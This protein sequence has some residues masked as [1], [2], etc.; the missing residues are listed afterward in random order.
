MKLRK[1]AKD[2]GSQVDHCPAVYVAEDDPTVMGRAGEAARPGHDAELHHPLP[3][4]T[5]VRIPA[6]TMVRAVERY[7]AE[8]V[9]T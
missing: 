4:E 1:L 6:D 9:R 5:A 2:P 3:D 7:L 8:R